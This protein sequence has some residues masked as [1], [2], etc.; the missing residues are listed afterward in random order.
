MSVLWKEIISNS[1]LA[2]SML[3]IYEAASQNRIATLHLETA[4]GVLSPSFQIPVPF[5]IA[6]LPEHSDQ[7]QHGLWLSTANA[8][9]SQD[10]LEEPGFL[11]RNFAL[12]LMDD[13]KKIISELQQDP[14]PATMS[15]V[16]FVRLSKPT[17]S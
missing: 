1:S 2:A 5:H 3:E 10:A 12:L 16:E 14:D 8:F 9:L 4:G 6:D 11:D 15:M 17:M 7:S 13:E